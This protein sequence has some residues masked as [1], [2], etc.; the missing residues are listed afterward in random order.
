M[1]VC[2]D[3]GNVEGVEHDTGC[4]WGGVEYEI[5]CLWARRG[6]EDL[7]EAAARA[8]AALPV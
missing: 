1:Q 4:C 7:A 5:A 2:V 6:A 8:P 3:G